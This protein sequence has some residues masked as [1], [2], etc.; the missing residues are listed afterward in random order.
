M[1]W[2]LKLKIVSASIYVIGCLT[3]AAFGA[4]SCGKIGRRKSLICDTFVFMAA[5]LMMALAPSFNFVLIAR[6]LHGHSNA[7][8]MVAIPIYTCE[9]SQPEVRKITGT[10]TLICYTTGFAL[11]L[12]LG[13]LLPWRLAIISTLIFPLICFFC[14]LLLCPGKETLALILANFFRLPAAANWPK[15]DKNSATRCVVLIFENAAFGLFWNKATK[16]KT[17]ISL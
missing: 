9:I 5:T 7:S 12:I 2:N 3:G 10:F 15:V 1:K 6:F 4:L 11:A 16:I 14:L 8:A 13:A 17:K